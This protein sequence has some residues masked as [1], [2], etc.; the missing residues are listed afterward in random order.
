MQFRFK[1][2]R[3]ASILGILPETES[4]FDDEA[5]NYSFP[6]R[7][8]MRLKK[9]MGF[10][11]HR[12][13]KAASCVSDFGVYGLQYMFTHNWLNPEDIG[14]LVVVTASP[15][16]FL[17][18]VSNIVQGRLGLGRDVLCMDIPQGCCGF[19]LGLIE[20][21]MLLEHMP[22]K[23]VV[24]VN[25]DVL[26]HI[27]SRQ[28]RN[29]FPLAGDSAAVT[30]IENADSEEIFCELDFDGTRADVLKIPA[31]GF[32]MPCTPETAVM[33]D[34]GSGNFRSLNN[35]YMDGYEVFNFIMNEV[36]DILARVYAQ[37]GKKLEETE[38]FLFHQPNK[39]ILQKLAKAANI[40]E[41][42]MPMNLVENYGN[43]SGASIPVV[44]AMNLRDKLLEGEIECCMSAFGS[45]LAW[46]VILMKLGRLDHC[47]II[48]SEL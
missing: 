18:H 1:N 21:F 27:A 5:K 13:A 17:P 42:K 41:E 33:H 14:A 7:Q 6:E 23:K 10:N 43:P 37:T 4:F 9:V 16:H 28:D 22:A 38:Y 26:S 24:L 31:G 40:P 15:D 39:F 36:P 35:M 45:G 46:G 11:K 47:E 20:S 29:E 19:L 32:R 34:D 12:L 2:K 30:V 3:I 44:T 48:E 25:S 8:T